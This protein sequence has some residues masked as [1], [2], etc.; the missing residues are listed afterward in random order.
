MGWLFCAVEGGIH[1]VETL[2]K[3][4]SVDVEAMNIYVHFITVCNFF[5]NVVATHG[6]S[7]GEGDE[8]NRRDGSD[9]GEGAVRVKVPVREKVSALMREKPTA[10][11]EP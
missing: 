7:A 8:Q 6:Y 4:W 2:E 9:E 11:V 1:W 10:P 5:D 3:R